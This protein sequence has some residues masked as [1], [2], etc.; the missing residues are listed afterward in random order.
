ML[1]AIDADFHTEPILVGLFHDN[2]KP[3][4]A[5]TFLLSFVDEMEKIQNSGV[6]MKGK[7]IDVVLKAILFAMLLREHLLLILNIMEDTLAVV[8]VF[9]RD[10]QWASHVIFPDINNCLSTDESFNNM[11]QEEHHIGESI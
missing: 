3:T 11:Q 2:S 8:N 10:H 4:D 7:I 5:N 1:V 6:I 9:K